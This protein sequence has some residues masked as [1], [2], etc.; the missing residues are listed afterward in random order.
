MSKEKFD[1]KKLL[2]GLLDVND[3]VQWAKDIY[4]IFN[5][6]KIVFYLIIIAMV[7]GYGY[8]KGISN[9]P[10]NVGSDIIAYDKDF[11]IRLDIDEIHKLGDYPAI[12]KPK[13]SSLLKYYN[14][15]A[16]IYGS[17]IK[18]E[19]IEQLKNKVKPYGFCGNLLIVGGVGAG[20]NETG[21]EGGGGIRFVK[22]WAIRGDLLATNKGGYLG[23]SYKPGLK[24]IPNTSLGLGLG[25]GYKGDDRGLLYFSVEL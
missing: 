13:N 23:V 6:R 9:K 25:K 10:I 4:N 15:R 18:V 20:I 11:T 22:L 3:P 14:W 7:T 2:N 19:D 16:D 8:W 21:M 12:K 1:I 24:Y 17:T 5:V